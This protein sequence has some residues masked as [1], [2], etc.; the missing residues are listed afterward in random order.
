MSI[1]IDRFE[2]SPLPLPL[3][4]LPLL[5]TSFSFFLVLRSLSDLPS[6][7]NSPESLG[8]IRFPLIFSI[9]GDKEET[10]NFY[11]YTKGK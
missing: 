4:I 11:Q 9:L 3:P 7:T 2:T 1:S 5:T 10:T 8:L 6:S